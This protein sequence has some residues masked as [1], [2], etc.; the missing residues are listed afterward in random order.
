RSIVRPSSN[1]VTSEAHC[2]FTTPNVTLGEVGP[3]IERLI[4]SFHLTPDGTTAVRWTTLYHPTCSESQAPSLAT[5]PADV[6]IGLT[7][8][9]CT[10]P[11]R[12]LRGITSHKHTHSQVRH[13]RVASHSSTTAVQYHNDNKLPRYMC[14]HACIL[15]EYVCVYST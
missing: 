12:R 3:W 7:Y 5:F 10:T 4:P 15:Y 2:F 8:L 1:D 14:M 13:G 11:S 6:C 9:P